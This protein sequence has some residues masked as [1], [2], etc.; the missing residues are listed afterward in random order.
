M[1]RIV[2]EKPMREIIYRESRVAKA[3][4]EPSKYTIVNAIL[5]RVS[6]NV[7]EIAKIV[8]RTQPT[9]SYHLA[10]LRSLDLV[11]YEVKPD[12][13]YYWIKYP[14]EL[15]RIIVALRLFIKRSHRGYEHET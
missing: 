10:Q 7:T 15:K 11:R 1:G 8:K 4:G 13:V 9:V 5:S 2:R 12:G 3:L 6:L 14:K